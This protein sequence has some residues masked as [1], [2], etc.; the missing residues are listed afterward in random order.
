MSRVI[1]RLP[2]DFNPVKIIQ[3]KLTTCPF[4]GNKCNNSQY[5]FDTS[6]RDA[7][8]KH[9]EWRLGLNKYKWKIL[10]LE[11]PKCGCEWNTGWYPFDDKMFEIPLVDNKENMKILFDKIMKRLGISET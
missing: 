7:H 10:Y 5:G 11:C 1:T 6:W 2:D 3:D 9:H 4:C 8:G